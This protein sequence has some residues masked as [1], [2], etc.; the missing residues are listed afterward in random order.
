VRRH[1]K[2]ATASAKL[3]AA[4]EVL[5]EVSTY[6]EELDLEQVWESI[7]AI[8]SR[9]ELRVASGIRC[10]STGVVPASWSG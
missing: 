3:A 1:P 7:E 2:L 9:P 6:G 4:A 8:V 5:F 10:K